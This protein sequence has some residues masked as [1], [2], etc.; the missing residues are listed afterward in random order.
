MAAAKQGA[1]AVIPN[2][3]LEPMPIAPHLPNNVS[4]LTKIQLS[5]QAWFYPQHSTQ[6]HSSVLMCM[7]TQYFNI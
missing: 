6:V 1:C 2:P 5:K 7:A 3:S 4:V